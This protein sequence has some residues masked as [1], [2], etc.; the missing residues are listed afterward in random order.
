M[1]LSECVNFVRKRGGPCSAKTTCRELPSQTQF[2]SCGFQWWEILLS[3]AT[4]PS[5]RCRKLLTI[6]KDDLAEM[7]ERL[8]VLGG[9]AD[10]GN[11]VAG[12]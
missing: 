1:I 11:F 4:R 6:R 9:I 8:A 2:N 7:H 10:R 3:A 5:E 12:L